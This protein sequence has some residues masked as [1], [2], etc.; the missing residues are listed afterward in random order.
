MN[1]ALEPEANAL[2]TRSFLPSNVR[3]PT[4]FKR[5][6]MEKLGEGRAPNGKNIPDF[7]YRQNSRLQLLRTARSY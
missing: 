7:I 3:H 5:P 4:E 6:L 2:T 1:H